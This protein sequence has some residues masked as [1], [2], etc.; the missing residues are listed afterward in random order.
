MWGNGQGSSAMKEAT[1]RVLCLGG[2]GHMGREAARTLLREPKVQRVTVTDLDGEA[3]ARFVASLGDE[4]AQALGLDIRNEGALRDALAAHDLVLNTTGPFYR[5]GVPILRAAIETGTTYLDICDDVEPTLE[6]LQHD[7]LAR[8]AGAR[9][10]IGMGASPGVTNLAAKELARQ[11]DET[12]EIITA[13]AEGGGDPA[14]I[15]PA[16]IEHTLHI[17]TG[18]AVTFRNGR[19]ARIRPYRQRVIVPFPPPIG[20]LKLGHVAHPEPLTLPYAIPGLRTCSNLGVHLPFEDMRVILLLGRAIDLHLLSPQR[21]TRI[22][23]RLGAWEARRGGARPPAGGIYVAAIGRRG[24]RRVAAVI[25]GSSN[26]A[27]LTMATTTGR[28][29]AVAALHLIDGAEIPP[30]V[31][32]PE[33]VLERQP[34]ASL[35]RRYGLTDLA[36]AMETEVEWIEEPR[37]V[38]DPSG[39]VPG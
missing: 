26:R 24:G 14:D 19:Q 7:R 37:G 22:L 12:E 3:A 18:Q 33:A 16:V 15:G 31:H 11:L 1:M 17:I 30:G 8:S 2:N 32:P 9:A 5:F 38:L 23:L 28:P 36:T 6:M 27:E 39:R 10:I 35:A 21:A 13:W 29:L 20:P 25:R 4:R 34:L